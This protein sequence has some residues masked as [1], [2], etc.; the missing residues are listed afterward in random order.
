MMSR[1]IEKH[2]NDFHSLEIHIGQVNQTC[3]LKGHLQIS[4]KSK[5][6]A[7]FYI[8]CRVEIIY[9]MFTFDSNGKQDWSSTNCL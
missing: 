2:L 3:D 5:M 6:L 9:A 4:E 8:F 1:R 7:I